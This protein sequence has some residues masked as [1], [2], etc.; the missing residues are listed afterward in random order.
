VQADLETRQALR[1]LKATMAVLV[2][3]VRQNLRMEVV[4]VAP[5]LLEQTQAVI[6]LE[7]GAMELQQQLLDL[8]LLMLVVAVAV[9]TPEAT[10]VLMEQQADQVAAALVATVPLGRLQ[11]PMAQPIWAAAAAAADSY[12]QHLHLATAVPAALASSS[13]VTPTFIQ[14]PTPAAVLH[15]PLQ[16]MAAIKSLQLLP[17]LA[18][19][20]GVNHGTLRISRRKQHCHRSHRWY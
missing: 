9:V 2:C 20:P 1:H 4:A 12:I 14:S 3:M 8:L 17:V 15:L 6:C 11:E 7:L 16:Q 5:L 10:L 19:F 18:T 13:C